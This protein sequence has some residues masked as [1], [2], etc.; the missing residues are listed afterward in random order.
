MS[1]LCFMRGRRWIWP[2]VGVVFAMAFAR[3]YLM[4]HFP[5]DVLFA[6]LTGVLSGWI[7][8][9]ITKLIFRL[10]FQYSKKSR[11]AWYVLNWDLPLPSTANYKGKH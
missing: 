11:L 10:C 9:Q 2:A 1:A 4:A 7:A 3:N 8:W 6:A 5:S